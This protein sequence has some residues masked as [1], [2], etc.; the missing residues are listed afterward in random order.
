MSLQRFQFLLESVVDLRK[1]LKEKFGLGLYTRVGK[2]EDVVSEISQPLQRCRRFG[3][4]FHYVVNL[5]RTLQ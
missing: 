3:L 1:N 5:D 4:S 2:A